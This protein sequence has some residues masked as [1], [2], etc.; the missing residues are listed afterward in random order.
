[1]ISIEKEEKCKKNYT[2]SKRDDLYY[3]FVLFH[4]TNTINKCLQKVGIKHFVLE[5]VYVF[6]WVK[7]ER[8]TTTH[9]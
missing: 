7:E 8:E 1:M 5:I 4:Y 3:T 6:P 9:Q 2:Y